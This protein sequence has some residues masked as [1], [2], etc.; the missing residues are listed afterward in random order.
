[1]ANNISKISGLSPVSGTKIS[2]S[3]W[4]YSQRAT[5][6]TNRVN[7]N[8][9]YGEFYVNFMGDTA[10]YD[11]Y[12]DPRGVFVNTHYGGSLEHIQIFT[13]GETVDLGY[14]CEGYITINGT[15]ITLYAKAGI[16]TMGSID[17]YK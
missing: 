2:T 15:N 1:M 6:G 4:T 17:W 9:A 12:I 10:D 14:S 11:F 16:H 7:S 8:A 3:S 13:S 5:K